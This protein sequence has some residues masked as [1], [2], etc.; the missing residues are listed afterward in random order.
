MKTI[1]VTGANGGIGLALVHLFLSQNFHV[2][3]HYHH[4]KNNLDDIKNRNLTLLQADLENPD[5][6][7]K[8]ITAAFEISTTIDIL[9]N[10]AG[11]Y[12]P[13]SSFE[14]QDLVILDKTL[15][16]NLKS[17]FILSQCYITH[18]K[19]QKH[20]KIINISSIGVKYGGS[21]LA[22]SYTISKAALEQMTLVM[23]KEAAK[24]NILI[25][26]IRVGVVNTSFH[27]EKDLIHRTNMIP[28]K[29]VASPEEIAQYI[30]FVS[31]DSN[32]FMTGS[33][34]TVAGGE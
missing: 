7:L 6:A 1:F 26:A 25:N 10:N 21:V 34:M 14:E 20:G 2:I 19:S 32:N 30:Y 15:N 27:Q 17:P 23:A 13:T 24:Y 5:E 3:A 22:A 8:L 12:M 9:V 33:I 28:L 18:M 11:T 29:R 31:S 16:V 4:S